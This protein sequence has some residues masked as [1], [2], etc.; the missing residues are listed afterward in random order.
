MSDEIDRSTTSSPTDLPDCAQT[1][2]F[3][4]FCRTYAYLNNLAS[5][6]V[7]KATAFGCD[8]IIGAD[9]LHLLLFL[10]GHSRAERRWPTEPLAEF[11]RRGLNAELF[12]WSFR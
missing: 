12:V 1:R 7:E 5:R 9:R 2:W 3:R 11:A 4:W 6:S 10:V 8:Y